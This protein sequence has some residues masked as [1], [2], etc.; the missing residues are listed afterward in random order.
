MTKFKEYFPSS[1][2][3]SQNQKKKKKITWL[4]I[5]FYVQKGT[6]F[7]NLFIL[8]IKYIHNIKLKKNEIK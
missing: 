6:F 7:K 4:V 1:I 5:S 2:N 8:C 3:N